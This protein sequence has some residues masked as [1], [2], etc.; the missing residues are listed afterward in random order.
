MTSQKV[1]YTERISCTYFIY[2]LAF[3]DCN[4]FR[5]SV[6]DFTL[7]LSFPCIYFFFSFT[8]T[9]KMDAICNECFI[10]LNASCVECMCIELT[11]IKFLRFTSH[12][13]L[14]PISVDIYHPLN[15]VAVNWMPPQSNIMLDTA[16]TAYHLKFNSENHLY[17]LVERGDR[18]REGRDR[19]EQ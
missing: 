9:S 12:R 2:F 15:A 5:F 1:D 10:I 6:L 16:G 8:V 19:N 11:S 17:L 14:Q 7:F 18:E 3:Y 4:F 13:F